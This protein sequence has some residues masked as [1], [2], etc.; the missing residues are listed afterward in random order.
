[1]SHL[2]EKCAVMPLGGDSD[3]HV[4][5]HLSSS[6]LL[7]IHS[8]LLFCHPSV[9]LSLQPS[10]NFLLR[11]NFWRF[12]S[13]NNAKI[14]TPVKSLR[15]F[16][17]KIK[18]LRLI[19]SPSSVSAFSL[20]RCRKEGSV[21][22]CQRRRGTLDIKGSFKPLDVTPPWCPHTSALVAIVTSHLSPPPKQTGHDPPPESRSHC[23]LGTRRD[24]KDAD[25]NQFSKTV[26]LGHERKDAFRLTYKFSLNQSKNIPPPP[27]TKTGHTLLWWLI[28]WLT[29]SCKNMS[30]ALKVFLLIYCTPWSYNN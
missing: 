19:S 22:V 12:T 8:V 2:C 3:H 18:S 28:C 29:L 17:L 6:V 7:L 26:S 27:Q 10:L 23:S 13:L 4:P 15:L 5:S 21:A 20:P 11:S 16:F 1:M 14:F 25:G 24:E 30:C 9:S